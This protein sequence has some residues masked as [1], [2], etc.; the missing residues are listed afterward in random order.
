[1]RRIVFFYLILLMPGSIFS[2][3]FGGHPPSHKWKQIN[4]DSARI[5]FPVG[6]DSQANRISS[7]IHYLATEKPLSLGN[8]LKK[9]NVVLQSQTTIPNGYVQLG[10]FRSEF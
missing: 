10:P 8:Q 5:I 3:Q 1:M 4:T 2:Q 7:I 6:M 9:I